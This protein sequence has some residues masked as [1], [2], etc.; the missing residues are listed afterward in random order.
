MMIGGCHFGRVLQYEG[1]RIN[2]IRDPG[3]WVTLS[4]IGQ[5]VAVYDSKF[6]GGHLSSSLTHQ[7][8]LIYRLLAKTY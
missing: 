1:I 2:H 6:S 5:S 3:H 4:S 8:A 7:L